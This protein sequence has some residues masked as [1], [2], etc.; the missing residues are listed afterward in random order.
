[1]WWKINCDAWDGG[2][3]G[4]FSKQR[5]FLPNISFNIIFRLCIQCFHTVLPFSVVGLPASCCPFPVGKSLGL[6]LLA[7][8]QFHLNIG[9]MEKIILPLKQCRGGG[10]TPRRSSFFFLYFI[11]RWKENVLAICILN[12]YS[13][14]HIYD[15]LHV[16]HATPATIIFWVAWRL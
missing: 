9:Y 2:V 7:V 3:N 8:V 16:G 15:E 4:S 12:T 1:M 11:R 14:H 10:L 5:V 6:G 13:R